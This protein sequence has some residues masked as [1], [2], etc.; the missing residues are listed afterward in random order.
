MEIVKTLASS[1]KLTSFHSRI[2]KTLILSDF[3]L[4]RNANTSTTI[5]NVHLWIQV[6]FVVIQF[7]KN[8]KHMWKCIFYHSLVS[9]FVHNV[10]SNVMIRRFHYFFNYFLN[11]SGKFSDQLLSVSGWSGRSQSWSSSTS[12][13]SSG[14]GVQVLQKN[15]EP[16]LS[17]FV[18]FQTRTKKG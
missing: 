10:S 6:D 11:S 16:V 2:Q 13:L 7:T 17:R 9:R 14:H 12:G 1:Y 5:S 4:L 15:G 18:V 8:F 3:F